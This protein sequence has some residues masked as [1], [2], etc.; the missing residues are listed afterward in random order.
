MAVKHYS[1]YGPQRRAPRAVGGDRA[2]DVSAS[3]G[4][5]AAGAEWGKASD[6]GGE[7]GSGFFLPDATEVPLPSAPSFSLFCVYG[8]L[9]SAGRCLV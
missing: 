7:D 5:G 9:S 4:V 2:A 8:E 1:E 6:F 3:G